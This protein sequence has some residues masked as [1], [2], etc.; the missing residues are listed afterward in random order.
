MERRFPHGPASRTSGSE[1]WSIYCCWK[2][3]SHT[4][5][6]LFVRPPNWSSGAGRRIR[7][8]PTWTPCRRIGLS[9]SLAGELE[10]PERDVE[11]ALV[12]V[13]SF[14]ARILNASS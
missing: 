4:T 10:L 6:S 12:R 8:R 9:L 11:T 14:V 13:R 2:R 5:T 3:W 1:T 7:G